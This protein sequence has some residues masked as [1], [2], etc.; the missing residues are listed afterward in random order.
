MIFFFLTP[1]LSFREEGCGEEGETLSPK[2]APPSY[3]GDAQ[4]FV[5]IAPSLGLWDLLQGASPAEEANSEQ[6]LA[7]TSLQKNRFP[8]PE[9][10][11]GSKL[12][13]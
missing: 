9:C 3:G 1:R 6:S 10:S 7:L 11:P 13:R 2:K 5:F 4:A 8:P 12:S